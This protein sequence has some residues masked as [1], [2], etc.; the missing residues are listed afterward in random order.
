ME[1]PSK[2][3]STASTSMWEDEPFLYG[4]GLG[5][6]FKVS[7]PEV[8]SPSNPPS[9]STSSCWESC[10]ESWD[11]KSI[12]GCRASGS[13]TGSSSP[14]ALSPPSPSE[15]EGSSQS[16]GFALNCSQYCLLR[17]TSSGVARGSTAGSCKQK[18]GPTPCGD[19]MKPFH[20]FFEVQQLA[21]QMNKYK[22]VVKQTYRHNNKELI[23]K[24]H[25]LG[26]LAG[27]FI[28]RPLSS[29]TRS[30]WLSKPEVKPTLG[31]TTNLINP[32]KKELKVERDKT[33]LIQLQLH[34]ETISPRNCFWKGVL[35]PQSTS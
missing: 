4:F 12:R 24:S 9:S 22:R 3:A 16:A 2:A 35:R 19:Y 31:P 20:T 21:K 17:S 14:S 32:Q 25:T 18:E 1:W 5:L 28:S 26:A 8:D 27:D 15:K 30:S 11:S 13:T 7:L 34:A 23:W 10:W 6:S 29:A 33:N